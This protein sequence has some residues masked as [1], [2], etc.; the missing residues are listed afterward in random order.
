MTTLFPS[1]EV[2]LNTQILQ[3]ERLINKCCDFDE[4]KYLQFM[5]IYLDLQIAGIELARENNF[6]HPFS[7]S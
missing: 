1:P 4:L 6:I 5:C 7:L 2:M 3:H